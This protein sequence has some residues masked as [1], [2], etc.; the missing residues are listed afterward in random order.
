[1]FDQPFRAF[2]IVNNATT[3]AQIG[4]FPLYNPVLKSA[5]VYDDPFFDVRTSSTPIS[6][7]FPANNLIV[8]LAGFGVEAIP[9]DP[10]NT[11]AK[12]ILFW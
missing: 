12:V 6:I 10:T 5:G 11:I 9:S 7:A 3:Y 2:M 8:N 4:I 1:M